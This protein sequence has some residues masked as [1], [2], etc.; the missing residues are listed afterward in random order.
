MSIRLPLQTILNVTNHDELG[1]GSVNGGIAQTFLIPQDTDNVIVNLR[2]CI[3]GGGVS[4]TLQTTDDG[5]T[6]WYDIARTSIVSNSSIS[7]LAEW[8]SV[9]VAG[10]GYRTTVIRPSVVAAG[11][12]QSFGSVLTTTGSAG[13]STLA[14]RE[15][16]GL[17][18]M[19]QNARIFIQLTGSDITTSSILTR[20]MVNS[21]SATA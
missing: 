5:G 17:P 9:P 10:F 11:S 12:V 3:V 7:A 19:S 2:A 6:T 21:Q 1:V 14:S 16:S 15:F 13:A 8:M 4:A 20:V 18:I